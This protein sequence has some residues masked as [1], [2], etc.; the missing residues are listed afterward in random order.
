MRWCDCVGWQVQYC[1]TGE[2]GP[3]TRNPSSL[4]GLDADLYYRCLLASH[5][6]WCRFTFGA[7]FVHQVNH[8]LSICRKDQGQAI[9][10]CAIHIEVSN[11]WSI[12]LVSLRLQA[13][14]LP[15]YARTHASTRAGTHTWVQ[16]QRGAELGACSGAATHHCQ[17][18]TPGLRLPA[19]RLLLP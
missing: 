17:P 2:G 1:F 16:G 12:P 4:L 6:L 13:K 18:G 10:L 9:H 11:I 19:G 5:Q 3:Q 8:I 14:P 15:C 7:G